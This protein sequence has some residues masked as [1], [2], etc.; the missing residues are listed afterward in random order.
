VPTLVKIHQTTNVRGYGWLSRGSSCTRQDGPTVLDTGLTLTHNCPVDAGR[1]RRADVSI[2]KTS[3]SH[4]RRAVYVASPHRGASWSVA[5]ERQQ[6]AEPVRDHSRNWSGSPYGFGWSE[7]SKHLLR[8]PQSQKTDQIKAPTMAPGSPREHVDY[9]RFVQTRH[10][11]SSP[12]TAFSSKRFGQFGRILRV[13]SKLPQGNC[14]FRTGNELRTALGRFCTPKFNGDPQGSA[15]RASSCSP[16]LS[17]ARPQYSD[18]TDV[19][20]D[21]K[22]P[23][24]DARLPCGSRLNWI[25]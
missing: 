21:Q 6:P 12:R 14:K 5:D 15:R 18:G 10:T 4:R 7:S 25:L 16:I 19:L 22:Q 8:S 20:A 3:A 17:S 9:I 24:C 11:V 1:L 23:A 13:F 2:P